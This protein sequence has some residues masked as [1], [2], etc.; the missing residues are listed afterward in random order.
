LI[1]FWEF[2]RLFGIGDT[3]ARIAARS[4]RCATGFSILAVIV[5]IALTG[6]ALRRAVAGYTSR[7]G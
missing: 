1:G 7:A 6:P 2:H 3:T 5:V 4:D